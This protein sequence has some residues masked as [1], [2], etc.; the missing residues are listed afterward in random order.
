MMFFKDVDLQYFVTPVG[1]KENIILKS[2][3]AQ[4]EFD[5]SYKF[6]GLIAEQKDDWT[7]ELKN[8]KNEVVYTIIAPFMTDSKAEIS[9][10]LKLSIISQKKGKMTIK[11]SADKDWIESKDREFPIIIDPAFNTSQSWGA[12]QCTYTDS[13]NPTKAWGYGSNNG[14]T[15]TVNVGTWG[16]GMYRSYI[17][18]NTLPKLN[19]GDVVVEAYL[20]MHL[21]TNGFYKDMYV[22]A[23]HITGAWNQ[24]ELTWNKGKTLTYDSNAIDY[25]KF[26]KNDPN[27]WHDWDVTTSVKRWYNGDTNNGIMFKVP[28]ESTTDQCA[29]FYS[30]NYPSSSVPRAV[31]TMVYRNNK[32]LEDYWT[33]TDFSVGTA[34]TAYINDY[35]GNLVFVHNDAAT[36]GSRVPAS[37][38]H[39]FNNYLANTDYKKTL[40]MRGRGWKT[41]IEQTLLSSSEFGLKDEAKDKYPYVWTD[42]DGTD[43]YFYKKTENGVDKY[44]DEDGL[45]LEL[46][47]HNTTISKYRIKDEDGTIIDFDSNGLMRKITDANGNKMTIDFNSTTGN[48]ILSVTDGAGKKITLTEDVTTGYIK[49]IQDPAGRI[50]SFNYSQG[51]I[52][53]ITNPDSTKIHFTY[54]ADGSIESITDI[55]G[56]KVEFEYSSLASGKQVTSIQEYGTN[57]TAGQ[58]ITFDRTKLNSTT[59]RSSG[60]DGTFGNNDD[61][62]STM[63]FDNYGRLTSIKSKTDKTDMGA[64]GCQYT[65][66]APNSSG[67]NLNTINRVTQE[68]AL[69]SNTVNLLLNHNMEASAN[70]SSVQWGGENAFTG[71]YTTAQKY[72]GKKSYKLNCTQYDNNTSARA[73]QNL[74]NTILVP[75]KTYTLSGY[76]KTTGI[77]PAATNSGACLAATSF[78]SDSTTTTVYSEYIRGNTDTSVNNGWRRINTT[79]TVPAN[80]SY[81]RI[82][83]ALKNATGTAYFDALQVEEYKQP[84][85]Y[86]ILENSSIENGTSIPTG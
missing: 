3:K 23:Y 44:Y 15:G 64:A 75:G 61:L 65:T 54:D 2:E 8:D 81:T 38:D 30:A 28:D 1:V 67:S 70:W 24:A 45:N 77:T 48:K 46:T 12:V 39:V 10:Q 74:S 18:I 21:Y 72:I 73:Y 26:V 82:N 14:Y 7:I 69:G 43:H 78:N 83:M 49:T 53:R 37:I 58:K 59:V 9:T 27:A 86:N 29:E 57:G 11:L 5:I 80:S 68:Y 84:N 6:N 71:A 79:F 16:A 4:T 40:P 31:F 50:T 47:I 56:Y 19:K 17:K 76:V 25:E 66:G 35:T 62:I 41:N 32:G 36:A 60:V 13:A 51:K 55:D 42:G 85:T 63:Q 22:N 33:Y 20:N 34:G 52:V